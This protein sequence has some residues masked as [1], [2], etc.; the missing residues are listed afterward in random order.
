MLPRRETERRK[1]LKGKRGE[2]EKHR[3]Q[4]EEDRKVT[5]GEERE[6]VPN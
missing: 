2:G 4:R 3:R 1:R 6:V 5:K